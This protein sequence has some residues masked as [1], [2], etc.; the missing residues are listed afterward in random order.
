MEADRRLGFEFSAI[1][2]NS[3][4]IVE[5]MGAKMKDFENSIESIESQTEAKRPEVSISPEKLLKSLSADAENK[6]KSAETKLIGSTTTDIEK[7]NDNKHFCK[8][9]GKSI[10]GAANLEA[11]NK[12]KNHSKAA[13]KIEIEEQYLQPKTK[14]KK[15]KDLKKNAEVQEQK[16]DCKVQ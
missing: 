14:P 16:P 9:C 13:R 4:S 12:S 3:A 8:P 11:H 7:R 15:S 6:R 2:L 1:Q 10:T 5:A